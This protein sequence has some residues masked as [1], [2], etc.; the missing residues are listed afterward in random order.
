MRRLIIALMVL[1][2]VA[3]ALLG[4]ALYNIDTIIAW[5]KD[6]IIA[7][8]ARRTGRTVDF[9]RV[10]VKLRG[11]IRVRI[12]GLAVSEDAAS[13]SGRFFEAPE[14]QVALK[15]HLLR[16]EVNVT[17]VKVA[18]AVLHYRSRGKLP[19]LDFTDLAATVEAAE[20]W[21]VLKSLRLKTLDGTVE[22][23]GRA[24]LRDAPFPFEAALRVRGVDIGAYLEGAAGIPPVEGTLDGDLSVTG[25]GRTWDAVKPTLAGTGKAAV[26]GGRV[27]EFNL[28]ER[29]LEGITGIQGLSGLFSRG[30]K[31]RYPHIFARGTTALE[32]LDGE[33][34]AKDGK[35]TIG[36]ITLRTKDYGVVGRGSVDLDGVTEGNGVLTLSRELSADVVPPSRLGILTNG[37]GE[38]ELP[39]AVD[40]TLPDVRVRPGSQLVARLLQGGGGARLGRLLDVFPGL[41]A[42]LAPEESAVE[43]PQTLKPL[44]A[45]PEAPE[46]KQEK[47][48][49]TQQPDDPIE[50]LINRGLR[51]FRGND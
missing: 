19:G 11:G 20:P 28:A 21:L 18:G 33:F 23:N 41:K 24:Q 35:A 40:G 7:A 51:I 13:G 49:T 2:I 1:I 25:E 48:Q 26:V 38:V 50:Q 46:D 5:N 39:F 42:K 8:A 17:R 30:L 31:D 37:K 22:A 27:L 9:D 16:R 44:H 10:H 34:E 36:R 47:T 45:P 4:W 14:V 43:S 6:R 32:Q 3:A 12:L 29:A 15:L